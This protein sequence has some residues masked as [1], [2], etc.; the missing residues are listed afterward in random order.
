MLQGLQLGTQDM[1]F[2]TGNA[3]GDQRDDAV[4]AGQ[5]LQLQTGFTVPAFM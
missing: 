1:V 3:L 2:S 4:V 5:K